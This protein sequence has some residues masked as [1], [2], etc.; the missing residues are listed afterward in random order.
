MFIFY[1]ALK[2]KIKLWI[3]EQNLV[4]SWMRCGYK[5]SSEA[6]FKFIKNCSANICTKEHLHGY[7]YILF[8][9]FAFSHTVHFIK[10]YIMPGYL[11]HP[12]KLQNSIPIQVSSIKHLQQCNLFHNTLFIII[13]VFQMLLYCFK[14]Y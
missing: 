4:M 7:S 9:Q 14:T 3:W 11:M 8:M 13:N 2:I 12:I 6:V 10:Y 5:W 1:F